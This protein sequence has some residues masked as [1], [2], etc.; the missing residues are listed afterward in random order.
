MLSMSTA[1]ARPDL[2]ALDATL[3]KGAWWLR[4][5]EDLRDHATRRSAALARGVGRR[6]IFGEMARLAHAIG[7]AVV[8]AFQLRA[9]LKAQAQRRAMASV[10]LAVAAAPVTTRADDD[11]AGGL[12]VRDTADPESA[13]RSIVFAPWERA[14][15]AFSTAVPQGVQGRTP[16]APGTAIR[17]DLRVWLNAPPCLPPRPG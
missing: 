12:S 13:A 17:V 2:S 3:A 11:A 6:P 1:A 14:A 15:R 4:L 7:L 5:I 16:R 9:Y 10:D 8:L